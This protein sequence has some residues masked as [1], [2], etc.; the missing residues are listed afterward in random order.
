[1]RSQFATSSDHGGRRYLPYVFTE[2]GAAMLSA[3][4]RSPTAVKV[5]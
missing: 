2:Q 3:V 4:L 5:N 1:M